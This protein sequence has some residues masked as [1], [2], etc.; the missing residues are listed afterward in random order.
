MSHLR[1][2]IV[3]AGIGGLSAG[4]ALEQAGHSVEIYERAPEIAPV[5]A[6]LCMWCNGAKAM[7]SLGLEQRLEAISPPMR[8]VRFYTREGELLSDI[9]ME[10][11]VATTGQRP[12]PV[13]RADLQM[14]LL[15]AHG[16][17]RV[18][19]GAECVGVEQ[20]DDSATV[21]FADERRAT[22]DLVIAA[23]G[24]RSA[25]RAHVVAEARIRS[26]SWDWEG[27]TD[28]SLADPDIFAFFVGNGRRAATMPVAGDRFYFFFDFQTTPE[29]EQLEM[30]AQLEQL[31]DG[32]CDPVQRLIESIDPASAGH[33][34]LCDLD[35]IESFVRGRV[36]L[37][38]DAAHATT[39]FLGQGA[40]QAVEDAVVLTRYLAQSGDDV[41]QALQSYEVERMARVHAIVEGARAK[42][43]AATMDGSDEN[44]QYYQALR[45]GGRDF[46]ETVEQLTLTGPL[47]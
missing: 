12:Y 46:V 24:L 22:A 31:Y 47:G 32:W 18:H 4:L 15:G 23:D 39:P 20:S 14:A 27:L 44:E 34:N 6:G 42:G 16:A 13:A 3:G 35:P 25:V 33:L 10:P 36:A 2:A 21:L 5:G 9:P 8:A 11:L 45:E 29:L 26:L 1:I 40:S 43:E 19:L 41:E 38:G 17:D 28:V 30:Q 7:N 37:L